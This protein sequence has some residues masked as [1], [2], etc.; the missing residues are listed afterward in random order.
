MP[1]EINPLDLVDGPINADG[2]DLDQAARVRQT[3]EL[4]KRI[5][6]DGDDR[7]YSVEDAWM[8]EVHEQAIKDARDQA[9]RDSVQDSVDRLEQAMQDAKAIRL[10][11][12]PPTILYA[13]WDETIGKL[14]ICGH[15]R[16]CRSD[17]VDRTVLTSIGPLSLWP[18]TFYI[19]IVRSMAPEIAVGAR[20]GVAV[21]FGGEF[22][23]HQPPVLPVV[24]WPRCG[25]LVVNEN[26]SILVN[27]I[28]GQRLDH[29]QAFPVLGGF[30]P[31]MAE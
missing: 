3:A 2:V 8:E 27:A 31:V 21:E 14:L 12:D 19:D 25:R 11:L 5:K 22:G 23:R 13:V 26:Q 29:G 17:E 20:P 24:W 6:G 7:P 9:V 1:G 15:P 30:V 16:S 4:Y 28:A 10:D 18:L